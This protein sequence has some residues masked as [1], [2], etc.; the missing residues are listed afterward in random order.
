MS[1]ICARNFSAGGETPVALGP[2][3]AAHCYS[4]TIRAGCRDLHDS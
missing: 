3:A 1:G 4:H 2:G